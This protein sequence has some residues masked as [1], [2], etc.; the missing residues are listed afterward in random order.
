MR[1]LEAHEALGTTL[2]D[3]GDYAA[4]RTHVEQ[5]IAHTDSTTHRAQAFRHGEASGVRCLAVVARTLWC[6]G[7]P[8]QAVRRSQE[9]LALAQALA[10]PQ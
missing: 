8:A 7:Y 1:R 4:A 6:L 3:L 9:A 2:F 10:P 5:G